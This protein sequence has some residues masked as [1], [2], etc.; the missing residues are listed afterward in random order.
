MCTCLHLSFSESLIRVIVNEKISGELIVA[1]WAYLILYNDYTQLGLILIRLTSK[2]GF[3]DRRDESEGATIEIERL[4]PVTQP[5]IL[6]SYVVWKEGVH[7]F[8]YS[9]TFEED[10]LDIQPKNYV[11]R[12]FWFSLTRGN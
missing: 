11:K 7:D 8:H 5:S 1:L 3:I 2:I 12:L 9:W 6:L 4:I 10:W